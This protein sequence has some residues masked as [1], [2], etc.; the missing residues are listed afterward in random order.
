MRGVWRTT[1]PRGRFDRAYLTVPETQPALRTFVRAGASFCPSRFGILQSR[2]GPGAAGG[3]PGTGCQ[4]GSD[5]FAG[6]FVRSTGLLPSAF[7]T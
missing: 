5:S 2:S 1:R 7:I 4:S 6:L 3:V